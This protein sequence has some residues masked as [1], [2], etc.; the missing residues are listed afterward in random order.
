MEMGVFVGSNINWK[1]PSMTTGSKEVT[2]VFLENLRES[3][4]VAKRIRA[5]WM[6]IVPGK[7]DLS[8]QMDYQTAHVV[9]NLRR[10][11]ELLEPHDL[12]MV[13]EPLN[14]WANHP[15]LFL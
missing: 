9:E 7:V 10:G 14:W 4:E 15:G 1:T 13:L 8:Q 6:T 2:E 5:K 12:V 3:I 11:A